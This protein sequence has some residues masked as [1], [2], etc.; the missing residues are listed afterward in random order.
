[1]PED[2]QAEVFDFVE[3]LASRFAAAAAGGGRRAGDRSED[4]FSTFSMGAALR[5]VE[6]DPVT[7]GRDDLRECWR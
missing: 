5:G 7:D 1:M 6:D 3:F 4:E 2:K